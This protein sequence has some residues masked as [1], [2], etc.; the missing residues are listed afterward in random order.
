MA[1]TKEEIEGFEKKDKRIN[2]V[3]VLK[4]LIESGR[5]SANEIK[6]NCEIAD[7]Y[8]IYIYKGLQNSEGKEKGSSSE[9]DWP[10]I[11]KELSLAIPNQINIKVLDALWDEYKSI[12]KVSA[13][14]AILL[15]FIWDTY[16][17]YPTNKSSI[18]TVLKDL[19]GKENE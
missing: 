5:N 4:S 14:P 3:A 7:Q 19:K 10:E 17:K 12:Y 6:E 1:Y 15:G 13:N 11:A 16:Y 2:R 18:Q 8:V 9:P